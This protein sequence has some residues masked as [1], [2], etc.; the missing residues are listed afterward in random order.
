MSKQALVLVLTVSLAF[1]S[2]NAAEPAA[3]QGRVL[4]VEH[5]GA[6][7]A[8]VAQPEPARQLF[9]AGLTR[10]TGQETV[11]KAWL[12]LISTQDTVGIKVFSAPGPA[13]G[14]RKAVVA[15][16]IETLIDAGISPEKIIV[17]DKRLIDLR[18]AGYP[19][20]AEKYQIRL[21]GAM[22]EGFDPEISYPNPLLGKLVHGD[23]EFG[24]RGEG[25]GRNSYV[26]KLLTREITKIVSVTPLLNHNL[27]GV[28][29]VLYGL[30]MGSVD[31]VLRFENSGLAT[32]IPEIF[33]IPEVGDRVVLNVVDALICQYRGEE[34]TLLHY[35][36][37]LNQLWFGTDPVA[38]DVLGIEEL[39]K[40]NKDRKLGHAT[41]GIYDNAALLELGVRD[42]KRVKVE[43]FSVN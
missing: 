12:S 42:R 30:S 21:A 2:A 16:V 37:A 19:D 41:E 36:V 38:L 17:W 25:T 6:T 29:G 28:S 10:F 14:T 3:G 31:N 43:R 35:S 26:T 33:A 39:G 7:R 9:R 11:K 22:D 20:L 13:S 34:R 4:V 23:L 24:A 32:A 18:L 27:A 15:A 1:I 40:Y 8:F 5:P